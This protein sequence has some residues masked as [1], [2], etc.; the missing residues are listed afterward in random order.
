MPALSPKACANAWPRTMPA[1]STVWCAFDLGVADGADRE[2]EQPVTAER[3]E[4]VVEEGH[5]GLD[6]AG[7][8]AVQVQVDRDIGL[9]GRAGHARARA[10]AKPSSVDAL[11]D[12]ATAATTVAGLRYTVISHASSSSSADS[13]ARTSSFSSG[14]PTVMRRHPSSPGA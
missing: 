7:T 2:V 1:S 11:P 14:V 10:G 3:V 12:G 6:V 9:P 8:G 4:H 13:A 5:P